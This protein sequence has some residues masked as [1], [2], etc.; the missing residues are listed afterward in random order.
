MTYCT[1][2]IET[3]GTDYRSRFCDPLDAR[4]K[5]VMIQVKRQNLDPLIIYDNGN[6]LR[7]Y[8]L[9]EYLQDVSIL[10]GQNFKFDML[11]LWGNE[12]LQTWTQD[13][14][15]LW[16]TRTCD[17]LLNGQRKDIKYSLNDLGNRY[18]CGTKVDEIGKYYKKPYNLT[19]LQII[20]KVGFE[21]YVKYAKQDVIL[22]EKVYLCQTKL[23]AIQGM[24]D[25][26]HNYM[27]YY[28]SIIETEYNGLY[29]D[30]SKVLNGHEHYQKLA[31]EAL[32]NTRIAF[33]KL[34][35]EWVNSIDF[36][37]ASP[38]QVG[39][40]LFGGELKGHTYERCY[41]ENWETVRYKSGKKKG[42]VKTKKVSVVKIVDGLFNPKKYSKLN[43]S[44][45]AYVVDHKVLETLP[46]SD[47]IKYIL[48]YKKASK[49][50][51]DHNKISTNT[52]P[53]TGC[54]HSEF[55]TTA[56]VTGRLSSSNPGSQNLHPVTKDYFT[57]RFTDG[58]IIE[59]DWSQVEVA[60]AAYI[61]N[62]KT[63][64]KEVLSGDDMHLTNARLLKPTGEI[65]PKE[66]KTAKFM[67]FGILYGQSAYGLAKSHGVTEDE[68]QSFI[69]NFYKKYNNIY[70]CHES[71][72]QLIETGPLWDTEKNYFYQ[73]LRAPNSKTYFIRTWS[74]KVGAQVF[75]FSQYANYMIQGAA[76]DLHAYCIGKL[77]EKL[78]PYRKSCV[79]INNIH[80]SIML[81]CTQ[82]I[83]DT[84]VT[85]CKENLE[86]FA[87]EM[88]G[89]DLFKMD[90]K[91]GESWGTCE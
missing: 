22:T 71:L 50:V 72:R 26:I 68:A 76:G 12:S 77:Y 66:R 29:V 9:T 60:M 6:D 1:L 17:F 44:G 33:S 78:L 81:D 67:T 89:T 25:L 87:K 41:D 91:V 14:G 15:H 27:K 30:F 19:T 56:T 10:I 64:I 57:S 43:K 18:K 16:D 38:K 23:M 31:E 84:I 5:V 83:T 88:T 8:N 90:I 82:E 13:G 80:D 39:R 4:N 55:N 74:D 36:N 79:M 51:A 61:F 24:E 28:K 65:S 69:S 11:Y 46:K 40:V 21:E 63:L 86:K 47:F 48:E 49:L 54:L 70:R 58:D 59:C 3:E 62:D 37:P 53:F 42:E 7:H 2:D 75:K 85:L 32:Q 20:E 73:R 35:K 34:P 52:N 45:T